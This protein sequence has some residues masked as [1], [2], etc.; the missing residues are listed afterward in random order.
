MHTYWRLA[1]RL[2]FSGDRFGGYLDSVRVAQFRQ[3]K[4]EERIGVVHTGTWI[5]IGILHTRLIFPEGFQCQDFVGNDVML[6][7]YGE[8]SIFRK[9][10][11]SVGPNR[12]GVHSLYSQR[13]WG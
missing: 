3:L 11:I 1:L 10:G 13:R 7:Y 5:A 12:A 8:Y 2:V 6:S 9:Q 4:A